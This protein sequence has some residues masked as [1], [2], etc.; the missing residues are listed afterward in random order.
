MP[1]IKMKI[2]KT[3]VILALASVAL[4]LSL[5]LGS[6]QPFESLEKIVYGM[7]MRLDLP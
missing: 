7:H 4:F 5:S 6:F 1:K 3:D 2:D